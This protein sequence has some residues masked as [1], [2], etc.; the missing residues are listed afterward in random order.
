MNKL[1]LVSTLLLFISAVDASAMRRIPIQRYELETNFTHYEDDIEYSVKRV[2]NKWCGRQRI[3]CCTAYT[4]DDDEVDENRQAQ[5]MLGNGNDVGFYF[6]DTVYSE[7]LNLE[8]IY[9]LI[10]L[11]EG[12]LLC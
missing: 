2:I 8:M 9:R 3:N 6:N 11:F 10:R 5:E 7:L 12:D 1:V 4:E